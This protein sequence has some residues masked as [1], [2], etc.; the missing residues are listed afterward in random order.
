L[1]VD[2]GTSGK[3][4]DINQTVAD[5]PAPERNALVSELS[6]DELETWMSAVRLYTNPE[7]HEQLFNTLAQGLDDDQLGR[8]IVALDPDTA[9]N[10]DNVAI[11]NRLGEAIVA[12]KSPAELIQFVQSTAGQAEDDQ[13]AALIVAQAFNTLGAASRP[14]TYSGGIP[15]L[16]PNHL[17]TALAS[18]SDSQLASVLN[19]A[20]QEHFEG[21]TR[22]YEPSL[23]LSLLDRAADGPLSSQ[24]KLRLVESG[25]GIVSSFYERPDESGRHDGMAT[26]VL[27][28]LTRVIDSERGAS[29]QDK[30]AL[31]ELVATKWSGIAGD[32]GEVDRAMGTSL[33]GLLMSDT[34]GVVGEL[35]SQMR[36]GDGMTHFVREMISQDRAKELYPIV[37]QLQRG[38][39]LAGDPIARFKAADGEGNSLHSAELGYFT[40]A[41]YSAV[42]QLNNSKEENAGTLGDLFGVG[43]SFIPNPVGSGVV[44]TTG[45]VVDEVE[46]VRIDAY[47]R[48]NV[49]LRDTIEALAYPKLPDGR[50]YDGSVAEGPYDE[51]VGRVIDNN[52]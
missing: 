34:N 7:D 43:S 51:A 26:Q 3:V 22:V 6:D 44:A 49:E 12:N 1:E 31:F 10:A 33:T 13:K 16:P 20:T 8:V 17:E 11:V 40:G 15:Y 23:L 4:V 32:Y 48:D 27:S 14:S 30:A 28:S 25:M 36:G 29:V 18:L 41:V 5:L 2:A 9:L 37:A 46:K 24:Q 21:S 52:T 47:Q 45:F 50:L 19:A 35:E 42:S 38:N 39:D